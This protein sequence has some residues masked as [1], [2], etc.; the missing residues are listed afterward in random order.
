M[1]FSENCKITLK[2]IR[3]IEKKILDSKKT[4]ETLLTK[5]I[6]FEIDVDNHE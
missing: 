2:N 1:K 5:I 6:I 4:R 3:V